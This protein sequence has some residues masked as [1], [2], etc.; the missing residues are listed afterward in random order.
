[1]PMPMLSRCIGIGPRFCFYYERRP[2]QTLHH[3]TLAAAWA[4]KHNIHLT[5]KR[6]VL[7][8]MNALTWTS[9]SGLPLRSSRSRHSS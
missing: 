9:V 3:N 5:R 6:S 7:H 1:M 8:L 2:Y 4:T